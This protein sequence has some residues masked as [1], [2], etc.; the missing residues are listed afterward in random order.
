MLPLKTQFPLQHSRLESIY[1]NTF[2]IR[3]QEEPQAPGPSHPGPQLLQ[4]GLALANPQTLPLGCFV[5]GRTPASVAPSLVLQNPSPC[6]SPAG[7]LLP[8]P[9]SLV[10]FGGS[11]P[12]WLPPRVSSILAH[13]PP[14][15][16]PG[17]RPGLVC[18]SHLPLGHTTLRRGRSE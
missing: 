1:R 8:L 11:A 5:M 14:P 13:H 16:C 9:A 6:S 18:C 12:D 2:C 7:A 17:S 4:A 3:F 10:G 15:V